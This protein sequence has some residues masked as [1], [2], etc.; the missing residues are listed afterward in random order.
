MKDQV[1]L[2]VGASSGIGRESA[3]L[4]ARDGARVFASA[5]REN[6]LR[7]LQTQLKGEGHSIEIAPADAS[8][9]A[10]MESLAKQVRAKFGRVDV[11]VFAAGQICPIAPWPG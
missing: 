8:N 1:V 11:L 5:R 3:V 2:V 4:F 6:R 10:E 7:E 9:S